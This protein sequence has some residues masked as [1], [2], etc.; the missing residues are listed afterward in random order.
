MVRHPAVRSS[1]EEPD[2][3]ARAVLAGFVATV[4]MSLVLAV[5]IGTA[6]LLGSASPQ[7]PIVL[8]WIWGLAHNAVTQQAKTAVPV[9]VLV[10]FVCGVAWAIV[11]ARLV[12]PSLRGPGWRRGLAFAPVPGILSLVVFLPAVGGGILGLGLGAGPLPLL[13]NLLLHLIYGATLGHLYG[14]RSHRLLVARGE[15]ATL[16]DAK[17]LART[18]RA[19]AA[20]IVVGFVAGGLSGWVGGNVV[21]PDTSALVALL[22]WALVG[23]A[24]GALGG[25]IVGLAP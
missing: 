24:V 11:Y 25:S 13:G 21:V 4:L 2:W 8:H 23:S 9:V 12:A 15:A 1:D 18:E 19:I 14:D 16:E 22:V 10:H 3:L 6:G 5:A 20:G 17:I 7:A